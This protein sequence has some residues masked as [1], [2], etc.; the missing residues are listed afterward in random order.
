MDALGPL[1]A[2]GVLDHEL[3]DHL[4]ACLEAEQLLLDLGVAALEVAGEH[5][6]QDVD[7]VVIFEGLLDA[8]DNVSVLEHGCLLLLDHQIQL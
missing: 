4:L 2:E 8:R 6:H 5:N 1:L 7:L 3:A